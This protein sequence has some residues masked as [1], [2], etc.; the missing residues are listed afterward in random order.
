M[1]VLLLN[2]LAAA[3]SRSPTEAS[4]G[5]VCSLATLAARPCQHTPVGVLSY[6]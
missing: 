2:Y 1:G 3:A 6:R 5:I 4:E